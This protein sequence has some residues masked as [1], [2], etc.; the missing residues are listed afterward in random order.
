MPPAAAP[1]GRRRHAPAAFWS[2]GPTTL[3]RGHSGGPWCMQ[4]GVRCRRGCGCWWG[5]L[6]G[7][8]TCQ[9]A[10]GAVPPCR[11]ALP[12]ASKRSRRRRGQGRG[13]RTSKQLMRC[14]NTTLDILRVVAYLGVQRA[15]AHVTACQVFTCIQWQQAVGESVQIS[16]RQGCT[17]T[18]CI[19]KRSCTLPFAQRPGLAANV[20]H[21]WRDMQH[22]EQ[23]GL[24]TQYISRWHMVNKIPNDNCLFSRVR[25]SNNDDPAWALLLGPAV[26]VE[27]SHSCALTQTS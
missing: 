22:T 9:V 21:V 6:R 26:A 14:T 2:S 13:A 18:P 4:A 24:T 7:K 20:T 10:G 25:A 3:L 8:C 27:R 15:Q 23:H 19:I 11:G 17:Q 12:C 1:G 5:W 16:E